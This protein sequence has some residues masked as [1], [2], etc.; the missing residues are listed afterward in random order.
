MYFQIL[1]TIEEVMNI[2]NYLLKVLNKL[3]VKHNP[4]LLQ[5]CI[6]VYVVFYIGLV[7]C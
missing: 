7:F 2:S 5:T 3:Y 6:S 1:C 4:L